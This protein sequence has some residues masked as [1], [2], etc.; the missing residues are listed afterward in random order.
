MLFPRDF[1]LPVAFLL[2][3]PLAIIIIV[4]VVAGHHAN[5][6]PP[7]CFSSTTSSSTLI[8]CQIYMIIAIRLLLAAAEV[9]IFLPFDTV[10]ILMTLSSLSPPP[11]LPYL[12]LDFHLVWH[13]N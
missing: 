13:I 3:F 4:V 1:C 12:A 8:I 6:S 10:M 11:I 9:I 7:F 2:A 5:L